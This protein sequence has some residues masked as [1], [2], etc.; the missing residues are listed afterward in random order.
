MRDALAL[1]YRQGGFLFQILPHRFPEGRLTYTE[2][3][4]WGMFLDMMN[5]AN[6]K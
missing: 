1:C 2:R 5:E 6:K 3:E 4:L